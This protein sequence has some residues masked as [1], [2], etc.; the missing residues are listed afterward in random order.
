MEVFTS[1]IKEII[2]SEIVDK[3]AIMWYHI[4]TNTCSFYLRKKRTEVCPDNRKTAAPNSCFPI[5]QSDRVTTPI[6]KESQPHFC[7]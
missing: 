6:M 5:L 3:N 4:N 1:D 7:D 2:S